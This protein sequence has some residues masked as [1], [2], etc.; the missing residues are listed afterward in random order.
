[1]TTTNTTILAMGY[2]QPEAIP[3]PTWNPVLSISS[4]VVL[5]LLFTY[6]LTSIHKLFDRELQHPIEWK[7]HLIHH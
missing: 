1:M 5:C 4:S 7:H 6:L 3:Q 2:Y